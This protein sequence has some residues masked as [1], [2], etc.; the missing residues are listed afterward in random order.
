MQA[1]KRNLFHSYGI[2]NSLPPKPIPLSNYKH[3]GQN[4]PLCKVNQLTSFIYD[5]ADNVMGKG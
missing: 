2:S 5:V 1:Y 4:K 3:G